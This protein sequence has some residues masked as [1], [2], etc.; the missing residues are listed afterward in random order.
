MP[1]KPL[2]T[3]ARIYALRHNLPMPGTLERLRTLHTSGEL[4]DETWRELEV[5]FDYLWQLRFYN[6][7]KALT[8]LSVNSDDLDVSALTD[9]ERDNLQSVLARIPIFQSRLSY[10]FLGHAHFVVVIAV[11]RGFAVGRLPGRVLRVALDLHD[12]KPAIE[13]RS[14]LPVK[15]NRECIH[16]S[17]CNGLWIHTPHTKESHQ[18]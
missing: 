1:L 14:T 8:E 3:F 11:F 13:C 18:R 4:Q 5:V 17:A 9:L 15:T 16:K 2:E 12:R 7:I 6:Q 10:D